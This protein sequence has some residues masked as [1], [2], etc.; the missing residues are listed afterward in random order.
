MYVCKCESSS[1]NEN[2]RLVGLDAKSVFLLRKLTFFKTRIK[3]KRLT[4][5]K[6]F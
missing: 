2:V 6:R 4:L 1:H 3:V 5:E